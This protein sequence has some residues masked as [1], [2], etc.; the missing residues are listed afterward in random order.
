MDLIEVLVYC[1]KH[2]VD[3]AIGWCKENNITL[4]KYKP[5]HTENAFSRAIIIGFRFYFNNK[6]DAI[7]FK[8]RWI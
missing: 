2:F 7:A 4:N 1:E 8:L 3:R 5:V 6:E